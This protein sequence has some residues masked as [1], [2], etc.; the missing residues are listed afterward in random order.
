MFS[1]N[2]GFPAPYTVRRGPGYLL[3]WTKPL[4]MGVVN[5]TPDSFS[6]GGRST[7]ES[8]EH[9]LMLE[10]DGADLLDVGG[11]STRPGA[12][13]VNLET[14]LER[15]IPLIESLKKRSSALISIDTRKPEVA[16]AALKAGAHLVNDIGGL[17]NP[18]MLEVCARY[19]APAVILHMQGQ[20]Q[21]MQ[22]NPNYQDT[23]SE[24][25]EFLQTQAARA[26]EA[27]VPGV[28]LDPGIGFGK[29]LEHNLSLLRGFERLTALPYPVLIGASRKSFI[30]R[31]SNADSAVDSAVDRAANR[32]PGSVAVHLGC[33]Q[34]GAAMLRV[35]N[36]RMHKQALEVWEK[37]WGDGG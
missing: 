6:D 13:P 4:L 36:V 9:A 14:E 30:G 3:T 5:V 10:D 37:V 26:L 24:V 23:V 15:T 32:D 2:F 7:L 25:L 1:L 21:T 28:M 8:L 27:G 22:Q 19:K 35:H 16:E 17:T 12:D 11:E 33:V 18:Q 20:P 29:K 31:I 34:R